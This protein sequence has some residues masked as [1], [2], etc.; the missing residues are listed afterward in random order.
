MSLKLR[1]VVAAGTGVA[2]DRG[3]RNAAK[4]EN[5]LSRTSGQAP[6]SSPH[7]EP[8]ILALPNGLQRNPGA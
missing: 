2:I 8:G 1:Q 4:S 5:W 7:D 3:G 6:L